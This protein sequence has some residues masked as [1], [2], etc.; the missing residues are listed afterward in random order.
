VR[1]VSIKYKTGKGQPPLTLD[2]ARLLPGYGVEGSPAAASADRELLLFPAGQ[3]PQFP[4]DG[5]C[6][7]RFFANMYIDQLDRAALKVGDSLKLGTA[8]ARVERLG[9]DCYPECPEFARH[10][11]CVLARQTVCV[12]VASAGTVA[13]GDSASIS[14]EA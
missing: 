3:E 2:K 8:T 6:P 11:P 5:L 13:S 4:A 7:L 9:K 10:G 14:G 1:I 12:S